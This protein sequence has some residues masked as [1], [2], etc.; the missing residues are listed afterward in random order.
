MTYEVKCWRRVTNLDVVLMDPVER[1]RFQRVKEA[2]EF[3][4]QWVREYEGDGVPSASI[5][6]VTKRQEYRRRLIVW[7]TPKGEICEER[8]GR[9]NN[10]K[11][12]S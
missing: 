1:K 6:S 4:R 7:R 9:R 5:F 10:G 12:T 2:T 11:Q 8:M 3:A